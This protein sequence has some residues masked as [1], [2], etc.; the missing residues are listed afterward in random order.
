MINRMGKR[1]QER[2]QL[3]IRLDYDVFFLLEKHLKEEKKFGFVSR[4]EIINRV[5]RNT[6]SEGV[7]DVS[8]GHSS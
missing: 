4:S 7:L 5:L 1:K 3:H 8:D 2:V 6:L